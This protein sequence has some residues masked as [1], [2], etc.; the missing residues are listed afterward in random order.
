MSPDPALC[1]YWATATSSPAGHDFCVL[2]GGLLRLGSLRGVPLAIP[3]RRSRKRYPLKLPVSVRP[4]G[5]SPPGEIFTETRDVS[6]RGVY[7]FLEEPLKS[8]S[9]LELMLTLPPEITRG[10]PVRVRCQAL[11][12]RT[13][14]VTEDRVGIAVKIERYR[15]LPGKRERRR[16][17]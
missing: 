4:S 14:N 16:A 2:L 15:F 8:G 9:Q 6:S 3:E 11:V 5:V 7:F 17:S 13:E 12:Q 10:E 1:I